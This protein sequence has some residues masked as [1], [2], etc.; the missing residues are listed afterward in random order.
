VIGRGALLLG[1]LVLAYGALPAGGLHGA[2]HASTVID[3]TLRCTTPLSG[4]IREIGAR[5]NSGSRL[6]GSWVRLPFGA[7]SA[8][9]VTYG[10]GDS[11]G[12]ISAGKP[13]PSTKLDLGFRSTPAREW[14]TVGVNRKACRSTSAKVALARAG[15]E[16]G[17]APALGERVECPAPRT[18]LL[19]V[20]AV[21]TA[22]TA[23]RAKGDF[24]VTNVPLKSAR[25]AVRTEKGRA[26]TYADVVENG[27][28]RLF[29]AK[30]CVPA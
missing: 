17:T 15:L 10:L 26:L 20:R 21:S 12:W 29:T 8:G 16:G 19:R 1:V 22:R 11:L 23:L 28:A 27:K 5:A 6:R 24:L 4:G 2:V 3:V 13:S 14:G 9:N 18:V 30:G 7:A 25:L